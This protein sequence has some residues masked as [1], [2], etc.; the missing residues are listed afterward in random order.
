MLYSNNLLTRLLYEK[1]KKYNTFLP[2]KE[3]II[4]EIT[5]FFQKEKDL[6][7][8]SSML[9]EWKNTSSN[10]ILKDMY[11]KI[12]NNRLNKNIGY[13]RRYILYLYVTEKL[14]NTCQDEELDWM[15]QELFSCCIYEN[16]E[17]IYLSF[18]IWR[19][20]NIINNIKQ[21]NEDVRFTIKDIWIDCQQDYKK[22]HE[23]YLKLKSMMDLYPGDQFHWFKAEMYV[24]DIIFDTCKSITIIEKCLIAYQL[25]RS[26]H[27]VSYHLKCGDTLYK[28]LYLINHNLPK[29]HLV[30][31]YNMI[32]VCYNK[33][34]YDGHNDINENQIT[35]SVFT[36]T[37][38]PSLNIN[39]YE[40][41]IER[42]TKISNNDQVSECHAR[43]LT[44]FHTE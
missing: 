1:Q 37:R 31:I 13:I 33:Y 7:C 36:S 28:I 21:S 29:E 5:S 27:S 4:K 17:N 35:F 2:D 12:M 16:F 32:L 6:F 10:D 40:D 9:M 24:L 41:I 18:V 8:Y 25:Y 23:R 26:Y 14:K 42:L 43:F 20:K 15:E 39:F 19:I 38:K 3:E 34:I 44:K 30:Q 22:A 11:V